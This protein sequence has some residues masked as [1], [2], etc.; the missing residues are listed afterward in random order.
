MR[1]KLSGPLGRPPPVRRSL[2]ERIGLRLVPH[3][4][5]NLNTLASVTASS[6]MDSIVS[7]TDRVKQAEICGCSNWFGQRSALPVVGLYHQLPIDWFPTLYSC[8]RPTLN[9]TGELKAACWLRQSQ[10]S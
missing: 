8:H 1:R 10:Q 7:L 4:E 3:P 6:M 5:P 9:Q 2:Q